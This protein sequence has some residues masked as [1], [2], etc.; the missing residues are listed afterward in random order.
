MGNRAVFVD[1]DGT[2]N[3]NYG[4]ISSPDNFKMYPGIVK[5][6]KLLN[7]SGFKVIVITNQ[8]GIARG[9]FSKEALKEIHDKME[10]ELAEKGASVDAIYYCPHHP[11]ENCDCRKPETGLFKMAK[12]DFDID[13]KKSFVVGDRMLDVEAGYK[14]G[15]KTILVPEDKDK[16]KK[17][18]EKSNAK[19]DFICDNFYSGIKWIISNSKKFDMR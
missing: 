12:D 13:Y 5:G 10:K 14:L 1:R 17:E 15:C 7:E 9:Y 3:V 16:V 4:Y 8:S 6:I 2:I 19:P 11:D 18:Q